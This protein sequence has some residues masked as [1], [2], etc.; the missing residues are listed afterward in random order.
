M[1]VVDLA[2]YEEDR[3]ARLGLTVTLGD[4]STIRIPTADRWPEATLQGKDEAGEVLTIEERLRLL[5]G[6]EDAARFE[7]DPHGDWRSLNAIIGDWLGDRLGE[8]AASSVKS[9]NTGGQ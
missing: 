5:L 1:Q 8:S 9:D 2:A 7:A 6:P 3:Q 4:G